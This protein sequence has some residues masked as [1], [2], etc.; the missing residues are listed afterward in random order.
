[1]KADI[2]DDELY[3][4]QLERD[5][6]QRYRRL[7]AIGQ[8][9][10]VL[11]VIGFWQFGSGTLMDPFFVG[12]P[13]G[14]AN[15]LF[16]DLGDPRF[17]NDLR[18]TGTEMILGYVLGAL[19]G[20][21]LGV[22]FARWRVA[23]DVADPFFSGLNSL[24]RIALAPLLVI[25]FGIDM[26]SKIV[27]AAT[28]VFFL[29]FF[30]TLSGIRNV[31]KALIDVARLVG[32]NDRQIFRYVMLPGAAAWVINGLKLSLPYALIG[33]IVGE[34]LISSSGLG[35]RLNSYSTAYNTNGTFA[36]LLVMMALMMGLNA[37]MNLFERHA[38]RWRTETAGTVQPY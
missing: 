20:I 29:T 37:L 2:K 32:A 18:V 1:M 10:V 15:V 24:P 8:I 5:A 36:M 31:D 17:Y 7:V 22:L 34:F 3:E 12:S 23:A 9:G 21:A 28:L 6:R 13:L 26:G 38:L 19:S 14:T 16:N 4:S 33:V 35:Y 25:W 11:A 27:L 30:T